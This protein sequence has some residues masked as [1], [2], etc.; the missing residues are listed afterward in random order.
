MIINF[1]IKHACYLILDTFMVLLK[2]AALS[3]FMEEGR[4]HQNFR[5][6]NIYPISS[7][8]LV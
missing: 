2:M 8:L 1:V 5:C 4:I 3:G 7:N 6:F